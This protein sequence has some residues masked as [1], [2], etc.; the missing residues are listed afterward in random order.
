MDLAGAQRV[1]Q[2]LA[3]SIDEIYKKN[4]SRLSFEE[5]YRSAYNLVL[6]KHAEML[7]EGVKEKIN[8]HLQVAVNE[9][10]A[11]RPDDNLLEGISAVWSDHCINSQMIKDILMYLDRAYVSQHKKVPVYNMGLQLFRGIILFNSNIRD[12]L[13]RIIL[14]NIH[15]ER[16]GQ[17]VDRSLLKSVLSMLVDLNVDG[18]NV[19]EEDFEKHFIEDSHN[20]YREESQSFIQ[21]NTCSEY[22]AKAQMRIHEE[23]DRVTNYLSSSSE[24]KLKF[25]VETE[26]ITKHAKMLVEMENSGCEHMMNEFKVQDLSLMY[27]L[28]ARVPS[29]LDILR[30]FMYE[31]VKKL[32]LQI[33]AD[34]QAVKDPVAFVKQILD[35]K[36][37]YSEIVAKSFKGDKKALKR[38]KDSFDEFLN[39]DNKCA[40][41]LA[42]Y[43]DDMFKSGLKGRSEM[44]ADAMLD[45]MILIF[46]HIKDKDLFENHY[47]SK[48]AKRLLNSSSVADE[49][50]RS[51]IRKIKQESGYHFV[52]KLEGMLHDMGNSKAH[53]DEYKN[54][55]NFAESAIEV[56][57]DVLT[58]G[59]WITQEQAPCKLPPQIQAC[60]DAYST[61]FLN[62]HQGQKLVW[63]N[64]L[65]NAEIRGSF[66]SG[67]KEFIVSTYQMCI[68]MLFN[69][70]DT[71]SLDEIREATDIPENELRRHLLSLCTPKLKILEKNSKTKHI[72]P[73]DVF[74]FNAQFTSKY[75]KIKVPL[76]VA[77]REGGVDSVGKENDDVLP[78]NLEEDRKHQA[79][80]AIV[81]ILKS[82]KILSH[83]ELISEVMR[84]LMSRFVPTN[85]Y[86]K[87]R[88]ESLIER[89]YIKRNVE[90]ASYEYLA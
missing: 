78:S 82:R 43:I 41:Y 72:T 79:E 16:C 11:D 38:L 12:R 3:K 18:V 19:Y 40:S 48:F 68:L 49:I 50:E 85:P 70:K 84:Q 67:K 34:Q 71:H 17:V 90:S 86:I 28:F 39:K 20:F 76:I 58:S 24:S 44:E 73:T 9:R 60:R 25:A 42:S 22:L 33:V 6:H 2:D 89:E 54:T 75:R 64:Y 55:S 30:E 32:G 74:T 4:A 15:A 36:N 69:E 10:L 21:Q 13:R 62:K 52:S 1:W 31:H 35:L 26:L 80:A 5:L 83:N 61:F 14:G 81:R 65:G 27:N 63:H 29:I 66:P 7:Y 47:R 87:K 88:I 56:K 59:F 77:S 53:M 45:E 8:S 23:N 57:V 51:M 46:Q 37:K